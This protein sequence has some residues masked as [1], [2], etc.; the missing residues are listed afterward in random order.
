MKMSR[1]DR[2]S[3]RKKSVEIKKVRER[4]EEEDSL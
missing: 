3:T 2:E 4:E 1:E